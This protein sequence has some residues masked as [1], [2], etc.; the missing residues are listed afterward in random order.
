MKRNICFFIGTHGDWAGASRILFNIMRNLDRDKFNPIAMLTRRGEICDELEQRAIEYAFWKKHDTSKP[1]AFLAGIPASLSFFARK[2]VHLIHFNHGCIGWRSAELVAARM[3]RIPAIVHCQRI[4]KTPTPD[5]LH[6]RLAIASSAYLAAQS[7]TG[8][9]PKKVIYDLVDLE[10]FGTG[11]N[12]RHELGI[13]E[14]NVVLSFL[15]RTRRE[16]GLETFIGLAR[17]LPQPNLTFCITSQRVGHP[18]P[19]TYTPDEV[20][21]LLGSDQRIRYLDYRE[22]IENVYASSDIIVMPS[23]APEHCPAVPS[24]AG[25][26][27]KPIIATHTG[28]TGEMVEHAKTGFL[29]D[30]LDLDQL[31]TYARTLIANEAL[32]IEM[33]RQARRLV[34]DRFGSQPIQ[35][36]HA[37]YDA[38]ARK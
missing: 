13:P 29:V 22:D 16:K 28:A 37:T 24:E 38:L 1:M 14:Q 7:N 27:S 4:I 6:A 18:T 11:R 33:G 34:E 30:P 20:R 26:A 19:D 12:I 21:K 3:A 15:G 8:D 35:E 23:Q 36:I 32:R 10:R 9:V 17:A 2:N 5:L 31:S 25:A